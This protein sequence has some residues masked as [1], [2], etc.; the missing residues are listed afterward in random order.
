MTAPQ[1]MPTV[2]IIGA[3]MAG[4][5]C[6]SLLVERG[7]HVTLFDKARRA[8]GR[9][10]SRR[11]ETAHGTASFDFGAQYFTVRDAGFAAEVARWA[12][13]GIAS[14]W[15]DAREDAWI[16]V[17]TMNTVMQALSAPHDVHF[18]HHVSGVARENGRWRLLGEGMPAQHFDAAVLAL[19]AEQA[20]PILALH[21]FE[22]ARTALFARSQPCWTGM[23]AFDTPLTHHHHTV[24]DHGIVAWAARNSAKPGR[25]GPESWVVQASPQ[26]SAAHLERTPDEIAP[27]LLTALGEATGGTTPAPLAHS[28]HRWRYALS[29][30]TGLGCLWN[31][32][33]QIGACGDWLLG[34][35]VE[36]AWVSGRTLAK[37][38]LGEA[39]EAA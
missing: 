12:E 28:I 37:R 13:A 34:P 3:G 14:R 32:T 15:P 31:E 19:P 17:P 11:L 24:R 38:M 4:L 21:D 2:A 26:W 20:A 10:A 25:A 29:A 33:Q 36:C 27:L 16:G 18:S 39:R 1:A 7:W 6:A 8:G 5:S 30:G 9:M 22:L 35:R 23:F